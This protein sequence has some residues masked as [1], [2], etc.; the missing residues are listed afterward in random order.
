LQDISLSWSIKKDFLN[1]IG[2][3]DAK[4]Y[5]SGKNLLTLTKWDGWDPETG[6]GIT[7]TSVYPVMKSFCLGIDVSF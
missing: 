3:Q 1:G 2:I 6:Q 5:V 7:S 4:I